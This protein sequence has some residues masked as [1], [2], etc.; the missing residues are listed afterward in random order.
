M[1]PSQVRQAE[2]DYSKHVRLGADELTQNILE[3]STVYGADDH[4]VGRVGHVH[5]VGAAANI[6][7]DVGGFLSIG[8]KP[9]VVPMS[10]L[11]FSMTRT[12]MFTPQ[13]GPRIN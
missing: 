3:G 1:F 8:A 9:V 7:I 6:V 11:E 5:G 12:A 4:K 10:N 13:H 2:M